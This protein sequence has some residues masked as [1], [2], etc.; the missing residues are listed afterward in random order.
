MIGWIVLNVLVIGASYAFYC[1]AYHQGH[2]DGAEGK[3][4]RPL[5]RR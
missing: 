4:A 2:R 1:F 3:P 5:A